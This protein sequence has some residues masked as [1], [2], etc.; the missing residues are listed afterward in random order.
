MESFSRES[1][2]DKIMQYISEKIIRME[3]KPGERI[4]ES[5]IAQALGVSHSPIREA[6]R[7]LQKNRLVVLVPRKGAYVSELTEAWVESLFDIFNEMLVLVGKKCI[8]NASEEDFLKIEEAASRAEASAKEDN[9]KAYYEAIINFGLACLYSC[10]APLLEEI[11]N[12]LLPPFQ[13]ILYI[14]FSFRDENLTENVKFLSDG[15]R[16]L[17]AGDVDAATKTVREWFQLEKM[18]VM[19]G[20]R[21]GNYFTAA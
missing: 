13:R 11:I 18:K 14:S 10:K 12:E 20:L 19:Q 1:L 15:A 21:D 5:K 6:L 7:E 4:I 8:Q 2:V 3:Y 16:I 9:G 17:K